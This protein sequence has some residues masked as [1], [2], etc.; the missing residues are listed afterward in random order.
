M[1]WRAYLEHPA[2][3]IS[4]LVLMLKSP[5]HYHQNQQ[6]GEPPKDTDPMR[7]GRAIHKA[8]L[9]PDKFEALPIWR[10][11]RRAG[12]AWSD[13][14][15]EHG[16]PGADY[17]TGDEVA[18]CLQMQIAVRSHPIAGAYLDMPGDAEK[19]V[20]WTHRSGVECKSRIDWIAHPEGAPIVDLKSARDATLR[21]FGRSAANMHYHVKAA[22]Y[23][24][25]V[26]AAG[27]GRRPFVWVAVEKEPPYAVACYR[28]TDEQLSVGQRDYEWLLE[29]LLNCGDTWPGINDDA[30]ADLWMPNYAYDDD[31]LELTLDGVSLA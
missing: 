28:A 31:T 11:G 6:Y 22:F 15:T 27:F 12:H 18:K 3:N 16:I 5:Q 10:G 24:D 7:F 2:I 20:L 4:S 8:V 21:G 1:N 9:E 29:R 13:F 23:R 17:V 26:E 25:A 19:S 14:C 30:E